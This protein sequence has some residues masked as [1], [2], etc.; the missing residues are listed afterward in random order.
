MAQEVKIAGAVFS[1]VP[2]ISVPDSQ[3]NYH[4]F[5]DVSDTTATAG[6]VATGKYFYAADGTRTAG[7]YSYELPTMSH[8]VKGGAK[9]GD[10]LNI[11]NDALT[12]DL[13][14]IFADWAG[15][16]Q[17]FA[18]AI[19]Q[20]VGSD[21]IATTTGAPAGWLLCDGSAISRDEYSRL[22]AAIGTTW[23]AG[24]GSTTF[25]IPD[26]RG[27]SPIGAGAGSGLTT[28]T[29]GDEVGAETHNHGGATGSHTLTAA[30]SGLQAHT[31]AFTQPTISAK[32][33]NDNTVGG[34][35]R[36]YV[37]SGD[38][39]STTLATASGGAVGAVTGGAKSATSGHNHTISSDS[40]IQPSAVVNYIICMGDIF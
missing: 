19:T 20:T 34:S 33:S 27:R 23:G 32:Y 3:D 6:D 2:E 7:E 13:V 36:R 38:Q 8:Y 15:S 4:P 31:H 22:Y 25:N 14:A 29:L 28:R 21:G 1:D 39:S 24:D 26:L 18:G 16:I 40:C 30:E 10:Y 11:V 9:L 35:G 5:M 12:V 37:Q 17:M